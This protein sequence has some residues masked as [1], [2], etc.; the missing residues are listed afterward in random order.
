MASQKRGNEHRF[1]RGA[2]RQI[3]PGNTEAKAAEKLLALCM[4]RQRIL[5]YEATRC[6]GLGTV[7]CMH[8]SAFAFFC[9]H[10]HH[11][12][13]RNAR[14]DKILGGVTR[15]CKRKRIRIVAG[16]LV[17]LRR[18]CRVSWT[19]SPPPRSRRRISAMSMQLQL[20]FSTNTA[21]RHRAYTKVR[22]CVGASKVQFARTSQPSP[23]P[24]PS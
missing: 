12:Q 24:P 7:R 10:C 18:S 2:K 4:A 3:R 21:L 1:Q 13:I 19:C 8:V 14:G 15:S 5:P 6:M 9:F 17:L 11:P 23:F 22:P 20:R 16:L